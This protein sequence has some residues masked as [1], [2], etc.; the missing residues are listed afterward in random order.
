M[1]NGATPTTLPV[2]NANSYL[3]SRTIRFSTIDAPEEANTLTSLGELKI[4]KDGEYSLLLSGGLFKTSQG[5]ATINVEVLL[6]G[7]SMASP[8]LTSISLPAQGS[9]YN[10]TGTYVTTKLLT[11][12]KDDLLSLKVFLPQNGFEVS[13]A[14]VIDINSPA[15]L[16]LNLIK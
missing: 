12:H 8:L 2:Q 4:G 11:L 5:V 3:N 7:A 1:Y 10:R 13:T 6:N 16:F 15:T 9:P 14:G